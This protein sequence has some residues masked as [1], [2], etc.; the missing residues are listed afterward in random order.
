M[1]IINCKFFLHSCHPYFKRC[2]F[3]SYIKKIRYNKLCV[4][5]VYLTD[6]TSTILFSTFALKCEQF[7]RLLLL[8]RFHTWM[9]VVRAW[10]LF[11]FRLVLTKLIHAHRMFCGSYGKENVLTPVFWQEFL[12]QSTT[13]L[14]FDSL[15]YYCRQM[16]LHASTLSL[17][18]FCPV[19]FPALSFYNLHD[20]YIGQRHWNVKTAIPMRK[21]ECTSN[22]S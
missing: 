17:F 6:V 8:F 16:A 7:D 11:F 13:S 12:P 14:P 1:I 10:L 20:D 18:L 2:I 19:I 22:A 3:F 5:G 9:Q 15:N 21:S 4:T